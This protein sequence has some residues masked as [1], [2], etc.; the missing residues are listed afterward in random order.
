MP[1]ITARTGI[2]GG[3]QLKSA[4]KLACLLAREILITRFQ[5]FTQYF[6]YLAFELRQFIKKQHPMM[7]QTDFTRTW[8]RTPPTRPTQKPYGAV[9]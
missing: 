3:N 5:R 6:Q 9:P 1:Q 7:G 2:H 8:I 4:G